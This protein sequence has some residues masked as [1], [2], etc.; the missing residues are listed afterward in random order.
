MTEAP[1]RAIV[2]FRRDE[3]GDWVADLECG[4][5]QH[6]RHD[7]PWQTREWVTSE[8]GR[9]RMLGITVRCEKCGSS[10]QPSDASR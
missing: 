9:R 5:G 10:G 7:P 1:E 8:T 6:M 3:H 4:H 2:G